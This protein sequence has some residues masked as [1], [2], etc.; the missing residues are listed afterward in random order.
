L[1]RGQGIFQSLA[2]IEGILGLRENPLAG[3]RRGNWQGLCGWPA[4]PRP[5]CL[6][7]LRRRRRQEVWRDRRS[8][9]HRLEVPPRERLVRRL[10]PLSSQRQPFTENPRSNLLPDCDAEKMYQRCAL[11]LIP[12]IGAS[13]WLLMACGTRLATRMPLRSRAGTGR[14]G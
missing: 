6:A 7:R 8:P 5:R 14:P 1:V 2:H 10:I 11:T 4:V 9:I 3:S 13:S 12:E